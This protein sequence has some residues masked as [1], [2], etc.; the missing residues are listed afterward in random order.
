M[1]VFFKS[2]PLVASLI[3]AE[4]AAA[5]TIKPDDFR[6]LYG[7]VWT[8]T[9]SQN[10]EYACQ[11]GYTH[12]FYQAGMEKNPKSKGLKFFIESPEYSVYPR[13][14]DTEKTYS[15]QQIKWW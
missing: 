3:A 2:L 9:P 14:I 8:G 7:I 15:P 5:E 13:L 12:V 10:L 1:N 6:N 11:M 4:I